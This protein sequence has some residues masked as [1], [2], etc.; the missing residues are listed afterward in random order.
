MNYHKL[1]QR[2]IARYLPADMLEHPGLLKLL[3]AV[4]DSYVGC[5]RDKELSE[6][7][8]AISEQ[9][10]LEV[11]SRLKQEIAVKKQSLE[12]LKET[13]GAITGEQNTSDS[14]DLLMIARYLNKQVTKRKHA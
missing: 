13:I 12:K 2:Q 14:D 1:L 7:A 3:T 4:N 10:Y 8:F 9:E 11:N 5:E 6:R